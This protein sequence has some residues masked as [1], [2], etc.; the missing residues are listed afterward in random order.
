M[1]NPFTIER[2]TIT[3]HINVLYG[4]Q[5][6]GGV[7]AVYLKKGPSGDETEPNFQSFK[8]VGYS[9]AHPFP[10]PDYEGKNVDKSLPDH[11]ATIYWNPNVST[12]DDGKAIISFFSA[13]VPGHY[14]V[15]VEGVTEDGETIRGKASIKIVR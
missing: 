8:V 2:I 1:L 5:G 13:D 4:A 12:D 7:I 10:S 6:R 3:K 9:S 11:R 14:N 15:I